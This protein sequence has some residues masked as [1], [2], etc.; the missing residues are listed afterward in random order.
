MPSSPSSQ[1]F[2]TKN[3]RISWDPQLTR[4]IGSMTLIGPLSGTSFPLSWGT[5]ITL[6]FT[7]HKMMKTSLQKLKR[8]QRGK[9]RSVRRLFMKKWEFSTHKGPKLYNSL[10][11]R[12]NLFNWLKESKLIYKRNLLRNNHKSKQAPSRP[13]IIFLLRTMRRNNACLIYYWNFSSS[14]CQMRRFFRI[15][16]PTK[17][18]TTLKFCTAWLPNWAVPQGKRQNQCM[19]RAKKW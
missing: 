5:T 16:L 18:N 4:Q 7:K 19:S 13:S 2:S 8:S 11:N 9:L 17:S 12:L 14:I 1:K 15:F 3:L 10:N 6:K